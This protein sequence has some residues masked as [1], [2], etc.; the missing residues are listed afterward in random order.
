MQNDSLKFKS[1]FR[2][3]IVI[4]I[5]SFLIFNL[6]FV[7]QTAA[8]SWWPLVPCGLNEPAPDEP[9]LADEYYQPCS[10]CDLFKLGK[11]IIDFVLVGLMPPVAAILFVWGGFLI[12]MGGA[13][14]GLISKGRTIFWNTFI[15]VLIISSSWLITNTII[16]SLAEESITNPNNVP[17]Y[18]FECR[19]TVTTT[20]SP[21]P[22]TTQ[23][24]SQSQ[25]KAQELINAIGLSAFSTSGDC[26][27]NFNARQNIQ[28]ITAGKFPAV[29][30]PECG[31]KA[32]GSSGQITVNSA[33][34]DGLIKLSQRGLRFTV[35][36]FTTGKHSQGS[37]HYTGRG[38]DIVVESSA[39]S[40][41]I[42][43]RTFL[44]G[45]GGNAF[46]EDKSGRVDNDCSPIPSVVDHIHWTR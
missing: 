18:Q 33:L 13:N 32:G 29:C 4:F 22:T 39:P 41:W 17:W 27:G 34:L 1:N 24:P 30:S 20:T 46:C 14:P 43:A 35:T 31:C 12:L 37:S 16:K 25:A 36:S 3:F 8:V 11:N 44:N 45:L 42:E 6:L 26:G 2:F 5:F 15:G 10:R 7:S 9:R 19:E 38:V 40:V 28:D 23:P 21:P